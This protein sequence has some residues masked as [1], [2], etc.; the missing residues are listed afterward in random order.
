MGIICSLP[1]AW[2]HLL[3]L[4]RRW[5]SPDTLAERA[6]VGANAGGVHTV[7]TQTLSAGRAHVNAASGFAD[8]PDTAL[9][10]PRCG[11]HRHR[12]QRWSSAASISRRRGDSLLRD[13]RGSEGFDL[14]ACRRADQPGSD[15]CCS[16]AAR[17]ATC[18]A[19][20]TLGTW[21]GIGLGIPLVVLVLGSALVWAFSG[22]AAKRT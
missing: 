22:F 18:A 21:A 8:N 17:C 2:P 16:S 7:V 10:A 1:S 4:T 12:R 6:H 5:S 20:A 14:R 3:D 19:W 13:R 11:L 9:L 15:R